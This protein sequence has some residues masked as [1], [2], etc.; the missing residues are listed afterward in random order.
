MKRFVILGL[1]L[2]I[3][4]AGGFFVLRKEKPAKIIEEGGEKKMEVSGQKVL[5]VVA[6]Q[7]FRDEEYQKPR[8][9]LEQ[10]GWQVEVASKGVEEAR[11][12]LGAVVKVDKDISQVNIDDYQGVVFVGGA[13]AEIYFEDQVALNL[14]KTAYETGKVVGAICIAP[15][16]LANAGILAE[17]KATSFSS[18]AENLRAKGA[19]YSGEAVA[20][21]GRIVTGRGPE[22]AA[23]FGERLVAVLGGEEK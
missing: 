20:V 22:A 12:A 11:G 19:F 9:A 10:A 16:I 2:I 1:F 5:L 21:D 7:N 17:K 14:A 13:G 3:I 8:Q 6:P 23:E 18:E 15:S 4:F